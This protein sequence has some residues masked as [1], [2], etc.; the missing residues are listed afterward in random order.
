MTSIQELLAIAD[1]VER[2]QACNA[3]LQASRDFQHDAL[4]LRNEAVLDQMDADSDVGYGRA[5]KASGIGRSTVA[6]LFYQADHVRERA[7]VVKVKFA[8]L[9][10]A[11]Q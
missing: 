6:N 8:Q 4:A 5:A 9:E 1:P 7:T 2:A 10:G 3:A 11:T